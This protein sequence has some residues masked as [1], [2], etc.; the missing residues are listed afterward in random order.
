MPTK[1]IETDVLVVGHGLAGLGAAI[2]VK[3]ENPELRVVTFDKGSVGYAGK[4][5]KGGGHVAFIPEGAEETYVE[6]HTR[7]LGDYLNDQDMLRKYAYSTIKT[8]DRWASW[9]VKFI[10]RETAQNA[11]PVIPWKICLV[12]L[13]MMIHMAKHARKLGVESFDKV[14]LTDLLTEGDRVVGAIGLDL[15]TNET[16][17]FKAKSTILANGNQCWKI[18]GM[19]SSSGG[20]GIAA[21]YR[22]G[23]KMRNAEFGSFVNMMTLSSKT[24]AYGAEDALTNAK[25]ELCTERAN[26]DPRLKSV[27]GGVDLG[28]SQS[29]LM[30]MDVREGKGPIYE[31]TEKNQLPGSFIGRNLCCYGG[32]ADPEFYR[33]VAQ[34]FWDR[35][36]YKNRLESFTDDNPMKEVVPA[37]VGEQSPLYVDHNMATTL[38]GLY[39]AGDICANGSAWS[40]AVPTPP[41]RN[42]GSGLLHAVFTSIIAGESAAKFASEN[43][44]GE[45]D[46]EQV[47]KLERRIYEPLEIEGDSFTPDDIVWE[48]KN[49]M[50]PVEYSGYKEEG[51]LKEAL[52][53]VLNAKEKLNKVKPN[54]RDGHGLM[55]VN[56]CKSIVLC[57]E[58]FFRASIERKE[59]RG[60]HIREDY[61][62]RDDENFLKWIIIEDNGGE[63]KLSFEDIPIDSYEYKPE[64]KVS[65]GI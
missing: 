62:D 24:I 30:L 25:G 59:S 41:G 19:W 37:V 65:E 33:P 27:V 55:E 13:D 23:A 2:T 34:K 46:Q 5:N 11:H 40:G 4:A 47:A 35:L 31:D 36:Y 43:T 9:G 44:Y 60:W 38:K 63:M 51:R 17:V 28:G 52:N 14:A 61:K 50:Q 10:G 49:V 18:V 42:R 57:A 20:D 56:E 53:R 7:N 32:T 64:Q 8:M 15:L 16:I 22:A 6:Y 12:D 3:E 45:I 54:T 29:V 58:M 21:A 48:I 39:A 26:L 1:I